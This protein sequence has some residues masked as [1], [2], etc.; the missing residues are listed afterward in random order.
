M[1][2]RY[3]STRLRRRRQAPWIRDLTQETELSCQ[4]LIWP[5]FVHSATKSIPIPSLPGQMRWCVDDLLKQAE[6][7]AMLG[8]K[9]IAL[10]PVVDPIHKNHHGSFAFNDKNPVI[11]AIQKLK[12]AQLPLGIISDVALDPYTSHGHDGLLTPCGQVDNDKTVTQ[13]AQLGLILAQ[14]GC[15][16]VAPSDMQD[17][18]VGAIRSLLE[19]HHCHHTLILSYTAKYASAF[20]GPF[21]S[22]VGAAKLGV[23]QAPSD[24]RSY[25]MH[26]GNTDEALLAAQ[27]ALSQGADCLMVKPA[28]TYLDVVYRLRTETQTPLFCY[29]VSGEY[30]MLKHYAQQTAADAAPLFY[31]SLLSCKRA[32]A[33]GILS[34]YAPEMAK[35]IADLNATEQA[36]S[37]KTVSKHY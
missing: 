19:Q 12:Q 36:F 33:H 25:Q 29:Q 26:P 35:Y 11:L 24:K 18:T 13:L 37:K 7:L 30:A 17:G 34:Y 31:E 16:M 23:H 1:I 28:M 9:A 2:I 20:Y 21:R 27:L 6:A 10:F 5:V 8:I 14:A 4:D 15:D 32:G 3:P 22:A